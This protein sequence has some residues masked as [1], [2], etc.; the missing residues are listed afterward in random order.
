M[1]VLPRSN[2]SGS[3]VANTKGSATSWTERSDAVGLGTGG[4]GQH[5][6]GT[7][8]NMWADQDGILVVGKFATSHDH[9]HIYI[10]TYKPFPH[11]S[12]AI[13][14]PLI[15]YRRNYTDNSEIFDTDIDNYFE[16]HTLQ[17]TTIFPFYNT[18]SSSELFLSTCGAV[19]SRPFLFDTITPNRQNQIANNNTTSSFY[20]SPPHFVIRNERPFGI[21]GTF[22]SQLLKMAPAIGGD[23]FRYATS[24]SGS[25]GP[26]RAFFPADDLT[27]AMGSYSVY[28][29]GSFQPGTGSG[30]FTTISGAVIF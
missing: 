8:I 17:A 19:L 12:S 11:L 28:W 29:T 5:A 9:G 13:P 23:T 10:G 3:S 2:I 20:D 4:T 24:N 30:V 26:R 22:D 1:S 27:E 14:A 16:E 18:L 15:M 25:S 7:L 21:L 6:N